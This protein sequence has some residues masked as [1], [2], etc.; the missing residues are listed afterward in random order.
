VKTAIPLKIPSIWLDKQEQ[1]FRTQNSGI[2]ILKS[3]VK[4]P[5]GFNQIKQLPTPEF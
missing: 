1:E 4:D 2:R 3:A 5:N